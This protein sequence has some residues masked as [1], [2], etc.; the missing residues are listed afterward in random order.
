MANFSLYVAPQVLSMLAAKLGASPVL[1]K[2][3]LVAV[4]GF[5]SE[6]LENWGL[7]SFE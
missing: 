5:R 6:A 4:P 7:V 3:D 2:H 1:P